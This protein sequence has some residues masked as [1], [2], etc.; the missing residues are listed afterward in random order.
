MGD[1]INNINDD[2][3]LEESISHNALKLYHKLTD[4]SSFKEILTNIFQ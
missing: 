3:H 4:E 1:E 2:R